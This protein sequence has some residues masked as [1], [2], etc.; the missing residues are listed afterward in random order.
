MIS[1]KDEPG[2]R[3]RCGS[4]G[5]SACG[6]RWCGLRLWLR[7]ALRQMMRYFYLAEVECHAGNALLNTMWRGQAAEVWGGL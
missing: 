7:F 5:L 3:L 2:W 6:R 4:Y 1:R